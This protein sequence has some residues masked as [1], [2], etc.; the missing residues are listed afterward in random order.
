MRLYEPL[1]IKIIFKFKLIVGE[2]ET[3]QSVVVLE[4]VHDRLLQQIEKELVDQPAVVEKQKNDDHRVETFQGVNRVELETCREKEPKEGREVVVVIGTSSKFCHFN[5]NL[6]RSR[7]TK[8]FFCPVVPQ[9]KLPEVVKD[10]DRV[11]E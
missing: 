10:P 6:L 4:I 11:N 1:K 8:H 5:I 9:V 3:V 2:I 7:F